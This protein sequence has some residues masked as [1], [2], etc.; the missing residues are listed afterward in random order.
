[1]ETKFYRYIEDYYTPTS[2]DINGEITYSPST[3]PYVSLK[4]RVF[5]IVSETKKGYWVSP[6]DYYSPEDKRWVSKTSKKR[7]AYPTKSE[8]LNSF[9]FRKKRQIRLLNYQLYIAKSAERQV[10]YLLEN[11]SNKNF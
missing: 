3:L 4:E 8:A 2:Y 1:M 11:D 6:E 5:K 10:K 9:L 7:F